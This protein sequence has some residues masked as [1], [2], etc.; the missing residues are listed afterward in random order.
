MA[1]TLSE[2]FIDH[3][4][5]QGHMSDSD[6]SEVE[7]D[8]PSDSITRSTDESINNNFIINQNNP[9]YDDTNGN[10]IIEEDQTA[11]DIHFK[12]VEEILR[13]VFE[14]NSVHL[15]AAIELFSEKESL[16]LFDDDEFDVEQEN[17]K[18]LTVSEIKDCDL[19]TYLKHCDNAAAI[20]I[21]KLESAF[22]RQDDPPP[23]V[24]QKSNVS[25]RGFE[26][27]VAK[28][29]ILLDVNGGNGKKVGN[30]LNAE[31]P[32]SN[33]SITPVDIVGNFEQEVEHELGLLVDG[34]KSNSVGSEDEGFADITENSEDLQ[35]STEKLFEK[36]RNEKNPNERVRFSLL[37]YFQVSDALLSNANETIIKI[38][39][40][41]IFEREN[42]KT[43]INENEIDGCKPIHQIPTAIVKPKYQVTTFDE[44]QLPAVAYLNRDMHAWYDKKIAES[45]KQQLSGTIETTTP[46]KIQFVEFDGKTKKHAKKS[47]HIVNESAH[48]NRTTKSSVRNDYERTILSV[49]DRK[50]SNC[51]AVTAIRSARKVQNSSASVAVVQ[52]RKKEKMDEKLMETIVQMQIKK[53]AQLYPG[54]RF[55]A[56]NNN[57]G[58]V[59]GNIADS[60]IPSSQN[61]KFSG[62]KNLNNN[63]NSVRVDEH[64]VNNKSFKQQS[65]KKEQKDGSGEKE[66]KELHENIEMHLYSFVFNRL[67]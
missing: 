13:T 66:K 30:F 37:L 3:H 46:K 56:N 24:I 5:N 63:N 18:Y 11:T 10:N 57:Y 1:H 51:N 15:M 39:S 50:D 41:S 52:P 23:D 65:V 25:D 55:N 48:N 4:Q 31:E 38:D 21:V 19:K 27:I 20:D 36:V 6:F 12:K 60:M 54:A 45:T 35:S 26:T 16:T 61:A 44:R 62:N 32:G 47:A 2:Y 28:P 8:L 34:Y 42:N 9:F 53:N 49:V 67:F 14:T 40:I 64:N 33:C 17:D 58:K 29:D 59:K 43:A 22:K 7:S